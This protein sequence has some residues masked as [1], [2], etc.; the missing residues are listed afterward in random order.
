MTDKRFQV[1]VSS[2]YT[3]LIEERQQVSEQLL[4]SRCIPSG[5]E[6]FTASGRPPWEVI[7]SALDTTD[8]MILIIA[9]RYGSVGGAGIS[10]T[11]REYDYAVRRGIPVLVFLHA[12]PD[13]IPSKHV[14]VGDLADKLDA[15]RRKVSDSERHTVQFWR[16]PRDVAAKV[17]TAIA[18]AIRSE[19]RPGW[20]RVGT[21]TEQEGDRQSSTA[22]DATS[23]SDQLRDA[24]SAPGGVARVERLISNAA[25]AVTMIP[26]VQRQA[27]FDGFSDVQ[28][29]Y[30]QRLETLEEAARPLVRVAAAAARWGTPDLDRHWLDLIIEMGR[31]PR[32]GGSLDLIDLVRAP[33]VLVFNSAGIG[34]CAGGRDELLGTLLSDA[35]EVENPYRNE[36]SPAVSV[37]KASLM[38]PADWSTKAMRDYLEKTLD[39]DAWH[40][41]V[42]DRAWERWQYLV[43][44]AGTYYRQQL[45]APSGD[46]PPYLR[47]EDAGLS[48]PART[49]VGKTLRKQIRTSGDSHPLLAGG[50]CGA[51]AELF[52]ATAETFDNQYG[53]WGYRQDR[54]A[55]PG[56][57]GFFPSGSHYPGSR[58]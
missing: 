18:E 50:L 15:F 25:R 29:E 38:Y 37:L 33:A 10:F 12:E 23:E 24:L 27:K 43:A 19:P 30:R 26:F 49:T 42:F 1:F 41:S 8:Y 31:H 2:T 3:D 47:V 11:E 36:E 13:T 14:D 39:D 44:V 46:W 6:L 4:R 20:V 54:A 53:E 21:E 51:S 5:M 34:A 7:T 57:G 17:S 55:L 56:G 9:G 48:R 40:G 22:L 45:G 16:E 32:L 35:L 52:E 28:A 58:E